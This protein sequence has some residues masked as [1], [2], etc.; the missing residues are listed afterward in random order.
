MIELRL[1]EPELAETVEDLDVHRP[2]H[3]GWLTEQRDQALELSFAAQV[4]ET[5]DR[6]GPDDL[7]RVSVNQLAEALLGLL[8]LRVGDVGLQRLARR[9]GQPRRACDPTRP[10]RATGL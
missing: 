9:E 5:D 4:G 7:A 6:L 2:T 10:R 3:A 8:S 1:R